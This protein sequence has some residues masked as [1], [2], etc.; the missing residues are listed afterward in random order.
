M[1]ATGIDIGA[2]WLERKRAQPHLHT[3]DF[4]REM[5]VSEAEVVGSLAGATR[6]APEWRDILTAIGGMGSVKTMTRND[7]A[8]IEKHGAYE[9][10][11]FFGTRM[12]Q[13]VGADIDLRIFLYAWTY[14]YAVTEQGA[15]GVRRSLQFFD[16][17]GESIHKV[18]EEPES[19]RGVYDDI[20][21]RFTATDQTRPV[22]D[23]APHAPEET[24]DAEIDVAG[25]RAGWDA[26]RDT[27]D[28]FAL[29]K[30]FGVSR[31]QALRL[32]GTERATPLAR[33]VAE[34]ILNDAVA[35]ERRIMIFVGNRG[36][37]QIFI[38]EIHNVTRARG[39]LNVL[40]PGFNL[41]LRDSDVAS[42]WLVRKPTADGTVHSVELYD[43]RGENIALLFSK[44]S[45]GEPESP[46]WGAFVATLSQANA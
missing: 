28:F 42:A 1:T 29:L 40:D 44:R 37:I 27:H 16:G 45:I 3:R 34:I 19:V 8:V 41:H 31:T 38:G 5:N 14:A 26:L 30:E 11:E 36:L 7:S 12:G 33:N 17:R 43:S 6:L 4:A 9:N 13:T 25:L 24:P 22:I 32:A 39:W 46:E 2:A 18:Y 15:N 20:V 23:V 35:T 21:A 10:I